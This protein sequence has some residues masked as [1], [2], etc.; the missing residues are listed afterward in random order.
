[1]REIRSIVGGAIKGGFNAAFVTA[2]KADHLISI[3]TFV[4]L[5][6]ERLQ[7]AGIA[8]ALNMSDRK[9]SSGI[10]ASAGI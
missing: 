7:G 10:C 3:S 2:L 5:I 9:R 8:I 4:H 6:N 1:M